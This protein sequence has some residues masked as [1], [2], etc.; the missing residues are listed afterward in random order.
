MKDIAKMS[1][2][3]PELMKRDRR[4]V[5]KIAVLCDEESMFYVNA[6][7]PL[8]HAWNREA[9]ERLSRIGAPID[10]YLQSD[11]ANPDM[12]DYPVYIFLNSYY[13]TPAKRRLI[14]QKISRNQA[15]TIWC[16]A[17]GYLTDSGRSPGAMK[18]LTGFSFAERGNNSRSTLQL[19]GKHPFTQYMTSGKE[20][21]NPNPL[22]YVLPDKDTTVLG[23][24][25]G[26]PVLAVRKNGCGTQV[27]SMLPPSAELIR[28]ICRA[29]GIHLYSTR[30][31]VV[32]ANANLVMIHASSSGLKKI[33]LPW[34]GKIREI[35]TDKIF[36]SGKITISMTSGETALFIPVQPQK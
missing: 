18:Q 26:S 23:T 17:P 9:R 35:I 22:F 24:L 27:F 33:D 30:G 10:F 4:T 25:N 2:E 31:D 1:A 13:M 15:I 20:E 11:I 32:R 12:P 6:F 19:T 28:G 21:F 16:H 7:Q 34:S 29:A 5:A 36:P 8:F 14:H 3:E